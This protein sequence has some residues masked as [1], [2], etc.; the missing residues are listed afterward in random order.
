MTAIIAVA[1][2]AAF[3]ITC[4]VW[5]LERDRCHDHCV[6][7]GMGFTQT[8]HKHYIGPLGPFCLRHRDAVNAACYPWEDK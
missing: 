4:L 1:L 3:I 5:R 7:C 6:V 8:H 2:A